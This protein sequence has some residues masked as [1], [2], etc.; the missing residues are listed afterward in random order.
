MDKR[1][2]NTPEG[3]A[4]ALANLRPMKPGETLNP[5]GRPIAGAS[6]REWINQMQGWT[7]EELRAVATDANAP[8]NKVTAART[9]LDAAT[10]ERT[11]GAEF[12]RIMDRTEGKPPQSVKMDVNAQVSHAEAVQGVMGKILTNP[13]AFAAAESLKQLLS[14]GGD[15]ER[16]A[17]PAADD[18]DVQ[19]TAGQ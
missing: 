6:L 5:H 8:V 7:L 10:N 19:R 3:K 4:K 15:S 18:D 2:P 1:G 9:W 11:C 12:D 14:E 16:P 13:A 17:L